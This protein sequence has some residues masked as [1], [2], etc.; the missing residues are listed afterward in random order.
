MVKGF[1]KGI[2][3]ATSL[4]IFFR[5]FNSTHYIVHIRIDP[6]EPKP[7]YAPGS[8]ETSITFCCEVKEDEEYR[9]QMQVTGWNF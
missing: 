2:I 3:Y 6:L 5:F 9:M 1:L 4:I 7:W 8:F